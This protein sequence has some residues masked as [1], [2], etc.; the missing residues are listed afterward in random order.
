MNNSTRNV[1]GLL[2][3]CCPVAGVA[4]ALTPMFP[5]HWGTLDGYGYT[6][7]LGGLISLWLDWPS[8]RAKVALPITIALAFLYLA[9][10]RFM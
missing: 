1:F 10:P 7:F 6:F 4:I 8:V 5:K 2:A 9:A 3:L